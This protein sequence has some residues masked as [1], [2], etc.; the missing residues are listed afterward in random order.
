[1]NKLKKI[2]IYGDSLAMPRPDVVKFNE[3][4]FYL[5]KNVF[6]GNRNCE[7]E[8][9]EKVK[10]SVSISELNKLVFH[11][12]VY[13]P[14]KGDVFIL[15]AGIVDCAP[16]PV[17]TKLREKISGLPDFIK[18]GIIKVIHN[19]RAILLRKNKGGYRVTSKEVFQQQY[20]E[21]LKNAIKQYS[22]IFLINIC[23]TTPETE[24]HS[25]GFGKSIIE[26]NQVI[27]KCV[28]GY[29]KKRVVLI[30]I[31]SLINNTTDLSEY[32][33]ADGH[34]ITPKTHQLIYSEIAKQL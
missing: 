18:K 12:L 24:A 14:E 19:N 29:E 34:H 11:D 5:L 1:M 6:L 26:Y 27:E 31:Y 8:V 20:T 3:R 30:D 32:I 2:A 10:A 15:H 22:K 16:R 9:I 28:S 13:Y 33:L 25:P 4:Y 7:W 17:P 23:P 21:I